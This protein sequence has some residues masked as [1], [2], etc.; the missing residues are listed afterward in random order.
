MWSHF[1]H[2]ADVGIRAAA[3]SLNE[4][5]ADAAVGL[6]A[7]IAEPEKI[8]PV[9]EV[10]INLTSGSLE[11]LFYDWLNA[12]IYETITRKMLFS[13]FEVAI[14]PAPSN[15][16]ILN[17]RRCGVE[18]LNL[19]AT[20]WGEKIDIEKHSPAIEPKAATFNQLSVKNQNGKWLVQCVIDV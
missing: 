8:E 14:D 5:F 9:E 3:E 12:V 10:K 13:R 18:H 4:A 6:T 17:A 15:N 11:M 19:S 1:P 7:I 16:S 20:I 2:Q